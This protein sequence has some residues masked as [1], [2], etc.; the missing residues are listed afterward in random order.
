MVAQDQSGQARAGAWGD[1]LEPQPRVLAVER[2]DRG[3]AFDPLAVAAAGRER[4]AIAHRECERGAA[5]AD[6][7]GA[8]VDG[9]AR[10]AR[11]GRLA[12]GTE[13]AQLDLEHE[14][15]AREHPALFVSRHRARRGRL[16]PPR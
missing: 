16:T 1:E 2:H 9:D 5:D 12:V 6:P 8:D 15:R 11:A 7:A 14:R 10:E 3:D 13:A 4:H